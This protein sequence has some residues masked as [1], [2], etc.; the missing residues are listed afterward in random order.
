VP[1][2]LSARSFRFAAGGLLRAGDPSRAT[3]ASVVLTDGQSTSFEL[4]LPEGASLFGRSELTVWTELLGTDRKEP[5]DDKK[6]AEP[7]DD[8]AHGHL[9]VTLSDCGAGS[10]A[11]LAHG[12]LH[13]ERKGA[14]TDAGPDVTTKELKRLKA[15]V[16]PGHALRLTLELD[17]KPGVSAAVLY[18]AATTPSR[19]VLPREAM[20][21][22]GSAGLPGLALAVTAAVYAHRRRRLAR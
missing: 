4:F 10:C 9:R 18:D 3:P 15:V 22:T 7:K 11:R 17:A 8:K 14:V 12:D 21:T 20:T 2:V 1:P 16:P 19:L 13:L 5:K 6:P